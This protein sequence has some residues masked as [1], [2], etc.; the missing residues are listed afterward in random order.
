MS[1]QYN[2]HHVIGDNIKQTY[3]FN[4][5]KSTNSKTKNIPIYED[6]MI[7]NIK[8]KLSSLFDNQSH[9]EIYMFC[10]RKNV[11]NQSVYY[12]LLTQDDN[13]KLNIDIYKRFVSNIA[14]NPNFLKTPNKIATKHL[15]SFYKNN[16]IWNKENLF[17]TPI[18]VSAFH[19]KKYL[20]HHNPFSCNKIDEYISSDMK[21]FISTENKKLL[22]KYKPENNDIYF[23]FA[24]EVLE[25]FKNQTALQTDKSGETDK[26]IT[27]QY[28]LELYFPSLFNQ[29]ISSLKDIKSSKIKLKSSSTKEYNNVFKDYN[30]NIDLLHKYSVGN[31]NQLDYRINSIHFTI[32]PMES[33]QL[34]LEVI[35]KKI[36]STKLLS[37]MKYNPGKDLESIYRLYTNDYI[38]NKGLRMPSLY[39]ENNENSRKIKQISSNMLYTNRIGFYLNLQHLPTNPIKEELYCIL[40]ENGDIQIKLNCNESYDINK[41]H[42]VFSPIIQKQIINV[43]NTF[44]QKKSIYRF[45]SLNSNNVELN[46]IDTVFF[47]EDTRNLTFKN[48][49]CT[50]SVFSVINKNKRSNTYDLNYKRVSFYQKMNDI[51]SFINVKLQEAISI[52]EIKQL[53]M[54][55]FNLNE[56]KAVEIMDGFLKEI[57]L[58]VDAFENRKIKV[59]DN[60]GFNIHIE[61]KN[62]D[63]VNIQLKRLFEI[64]NIN[65][66]TYLTNGIIKRY[67]NALININQLEEPLKECIKKIKEK[68]IENIKEIYENPLEDAKINFDSDGD[69]DEASDL[70]GLMSGLDDDEN[71]AETSKSKSN[72][73]SKSNSNSISIDMDEL[74]LDGDI[75]DSKSSDEKEDDDDDDDDDSISLSGGAKQNQNQNIDLTSIK[76][77]GSKNWFTNRLR[78]RQPDIYVMSKQDAKNKNFVKYSKTCQWQYKKQPII[79]NDAELKKINE[80]DKKSNTKSYDGHIEYKG[81]NYICPRYWCFKDDNGNSRSMS[82][83][84]LN[85][86]ECGGWDALNPKKA[87]SLLP[88]KRIVELTDDRLHNPSKTNNP[89]VYKPLYPF[90]QKSENHPKGLCAPCCSQVPI[91]Y[92]GFPDESTSER[93]KKHKGQQKYF[94]HLYKSGTTKAT[95]SVDDNIK[96]NPDVKKQIEKW[97]GVGPSF[98]V[99]QN[100]TKNGVKI[101]DIGNK[102]NDSKKLTKMDLIPKKKNVPENPTRSQLDKML[103]K[104]KN[105]R[106]FNICTNR[107]IVSN[108]TPSKGSRKKRKSKTAKQSINRIEIDDRTITRDPT[109]DSIYLKKLQEEEKLKQQAKKRKTVVKK[110]I[111]PFLFEFPLKNPN[112]LG[113][114]KPS[115]QKFIQYDTASICYNN[116][117]NDSS[118]KPKSS[119]LLRLGVNKNTNQSFLETIALIQNKSL[120]QLK[121]H[122]IKN[123]TLSKY[124]IAFKGS[125]IDLFYDKTKTVDKKLKEKIVKSID[126]TIVNDFILL[127]HVGEKLI[128]SY[129]N[130]LD[131]LKDDNVKIDY[132][133][134]WD[135]ICK[136]NNKNNAGVLFKE[137]IN[138]VIFN[139][140]QDDITD[141]IE[142]ICPKNTFTNEIF[143]EFKPTVMLYKE[144]YYFEPI[145]EYNNTTGKTKILFDYDTLISETMLHTLFT[146]IKNKMIEGCSLKPSMPAKYDYRRNISAKEIIDMLESINNKSNDEQKKSNTKTV[147]V[148]KQVVHYNYKTVA[149]IAKVNNKNVYIPCHPSSILI[150]I[151]FE[152]YDSDK[153]LFDAVDTFNQLTYLAKTHKLPCLPIKILITD[154]AN[155]TGFIT[156]T[157]QVVP[158]TQLDYVENMFS[159]VDRK[160]KIISKKKSIINIT[161][162]SEYFS[163]KQSMKRPIE[164]I[165]RILIIRNFL[166]EKNFYNCFRNI[167]KKQIGKENNGNLRQQLIDLLDTTYK[168][169]TGDSLKQYQ[170]KFKKVNTIV[171]KLLTDKTVAFVIYENNVLD[172]LY[173][174]IKQDVNICFTDNNAIALPRK[175]LMDNSLN[176]EKYFI[177]LIDELIR[178]PRL[179]DYILRNKSTTSIDI[180]NY[181]IKNDEVVILEE[182]MFTDYLTNVVL[183]EK[184]KYINTNQVGFSKPIITKPY[185]TIFSLNY[186]GNTDTEQDTSKQSLNTE[187][188]SIPNHIP[189]DVDQYAPSTINE[190]PAT[191]KLATSLNKKVIS[192]YFYKYDL[193]SNLSFYKMSAPH[194]Q[195]TKTK[196]KEN[197][198]WNIIQE[199]YKDYYNR[200][201]TKLEL[202]KTLVSILKN[203]HNETQFITKPGVF[204]INKQLDASNDTRDDSFIPNY[205]YILSITH[206]K[207]WETEW[208][209]IEEVE[210][211]QWKHLFNIVSNKRF[212]ITEFEMYLLCDYFKLPCVLHGT[213]ERKAPIDLYNLSKIKY[214]DPLYTTF[215]LNNIGNKPNDA[216]IEL[217]KNNLYTNKNNDKYCYIIGFIQFRISDYYNQK[218]IKNNF[219]MNR[220][221]R[222]ENNIPFDVGLMKNS[223]GYYKIQTSNEYI[224]NLLNNSI[225]PT[226]KQYI[227]LIFKGKP[228]IYEGHLKEYILFKKLKSERGIKKKLKI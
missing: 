139:T 173:K 93:D 70:F 116:P 226:S 214:Y 34:P 30:N 141:K 60:P 211:N 178:F 100:K 152:F 213:V 73:K 186:K 80:A 147:R 200:E 193:N 120:R 61:T 209:R 155:V 183:E 223:D 188:R 130:F 124:I 187:S 125:L 157:N 117:P 221:Y 66:I 38:S 45:E 197:C 69:D 77:K 145:I 49:K 142:I 58:A 96:N 163:D 113:Y 184:N 29:K 192:K 121:T 108:I 65:D 8:H 102:N 179:R 180:I 191:C 82:F 174:K 222:K 202:C 43:V 4:D 15:S 47:T 206:R 72:N 158:T 159:M 177:K 42:R 129:L 112:S 54:S 97:E 110:K 99:V 6:D 24:D 166:L 78:E 114:L 172:E 20:F 118:L 13:I 203:M 189:K 33:L 83:K 57:R 135:F 150:D 55:N 64:K 154:N 26:T 136:P 131:Y 151:E 138:L 35:F 132:S 16:K 10:K 94:E 205:Y 74:D 98:K 111:K 194:I 90:F 104:T 106:R 119:C 175:N 228:S 195:E 144:G 196:L 170:V 52:E 19:R 5:K 17:V 169:K 156:E 153:I 1:K 21:K 86:G 85:D 28:L 182:E 181:S 161:E 3:I 22:F 12:Q 215:N 39:V 9:H 168:T 137:G 218:G 225:H 51:Q 201:I 115:L 134:L 50:S 18:G 46:K 95:I 67:L 92:D 32:H 126:D 36:N 25:F 107:Q 14:I 164:D 165:E 176:K 199:I 227:D 37:L 204:K 123:I 56:E 140:P 127:E 81:Y 44:V 216:D 146:D 190:T 27:D 88:G 217:I 48:L 133:Y 207:E 53:V 171:N 68:Q 75:L 109:P 198:T 143:S 185:S 71:E 162:H 91:E 212:Y 84:Q 220:Y 87:K 101:I 224:K 7:I 41:L 23:C 79:L 63:Y 89:L 62:V 210:E 11:L 208:P 40:L 59:E 2:F 160:G 103:Q 122:L 149:I 219:G 167:F 31:L 76:M 128:N 105:N 148:L